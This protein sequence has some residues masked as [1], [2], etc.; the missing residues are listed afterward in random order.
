MHTQGKVA[1]TQILAAEVGLL[2]EPHFSG[3]G[4]A[5]CQRNVV[6][7]YQSLAAGR[8]SSDLWGGH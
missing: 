3:E 5:A 2:S 7:C 4:G 6:A 8:S 1:S